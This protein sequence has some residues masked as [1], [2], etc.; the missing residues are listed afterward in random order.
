MYK[1]NIESK[2]C[3]VYAHLSKSGVFKAEQSSRFSLYS[4][5]AIVIVTVEDTNRTGQ[6]AKE[7]DYMDISFVLTSICT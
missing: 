2:I 4:K 5:L 1:Q 7:I 6:I 3:I